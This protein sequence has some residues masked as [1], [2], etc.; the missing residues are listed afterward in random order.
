VLRMGRKPE[1]VE[2]EGRVEQQPVTNNVITNQF[3]NQHT[4]VAPPERPGNGVS[5]V[6]S[7]DTSRNMKAFTET[8]NL[9]RG[10]KEGTVSGFVG[11]GASVQGE[12]SFNG[13]MRVDGRLTGSIKSEKGTLIVSY[14]GTVEAVIE[15]AVAN[16]NGTVR[17]DIIAS[18]RI[19]MGRS[20]H[21]IGNIRTP[22]LV[23]EQGAIFEGSCKMTSAE[24]RMPSTSMDA[25]RQKPGKGPEVSPSSDASKVPA[26]VK[27][28]AA[29]AEKA[30][31][32]VQASR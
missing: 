31:N 24:K 22:S 7:T 21:V 19:E 4:S 26:G 2:A 10:I 3:A 29:E 5:G 15:V 12:A 9:A 28:E 16:I 25:N 13:M 30:S 32:G 14:G 1:T 18:E 23:I 11:A 17:G 6:G 27:L 8:E 20:A